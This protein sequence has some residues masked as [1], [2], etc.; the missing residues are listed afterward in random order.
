MQILHEYDSCCF[1]PHGRHEAMLG[2]EADIRNELLSQPSHG[3][4]T[5]AADNHSKHEVCAQDKTIIRT[6]LEAGGFPPGS[7]F[8]ESIPC[9][10]M[11][12]PLPANCAADAEPGLPPPE[13]ATQPGYTF[14]GH[15]ACRDHAGKYPAWGGYRGD[16]TVC[17]AKCSSDATCTAYMSTGYDPLDPNSQN[18]CQF[19]C[20][21]GESSLCNTAGNGGGAPTTNDGS[22]FNRYCWL[23]V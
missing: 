3:W 23:K 2:Y 16:N 22:S 8:W 1:S 9:D 18:Y 7:R 20:F 4:F 6:A 11:H 19:Y 21:A 10:M 15:G 17:Q 14:L 5:V 13:P 12:Q